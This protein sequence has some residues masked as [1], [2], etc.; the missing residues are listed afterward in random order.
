[1]PKTH[2]GSRKAVESAE[3]GSVGGSGGDIG[4]EVVL[5]EHPLARQ[6]VDVRGGKVIVAV[7]AHIISF[8]AVNPE[9]YNVLLFGAHVFTSYYLVRRQS[10]VRTV[11]CFGRESSRD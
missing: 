4:A 8:E 1:M 11:S 10:V 2:Y 9:Q 3:H 5:E 7:T 6:S